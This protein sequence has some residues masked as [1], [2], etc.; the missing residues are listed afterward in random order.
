[1]PARGASSLWS[2]VVPYPGRSLRVQA[3]C[4]LWGQSC[5]SMMAAQKMGMMA[6]AER[7]LKLRGEYQSE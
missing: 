2:E 6:W 5:R 1:M 4:G 7:R 3:P